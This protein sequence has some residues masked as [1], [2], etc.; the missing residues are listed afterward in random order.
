MCNL[1]IIIFLY[2][3]RYYE[4]DSDD[5]LLYSLRYKSILEYPEILVIM[6]IHKEAFSDL[7]YVDNLPYKKSIKSY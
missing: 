1:T 2:C 7:L 4:L 3:F 6:S 5:T